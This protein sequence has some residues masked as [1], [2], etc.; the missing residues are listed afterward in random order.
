MNRY[1]L[2][3]C[4]LFVGLEVAL[5]IAPADALKL[6]PVRRAGRGLA[7]R[8]GSCQPIGNQPLLAV[9][10]L[11]KTDRGDILAVSTPQSAYP[12]L[13]FYVPY[14]ITPQRPAE[15][16]LESPDPADPAYRQQRTVVRLTQASAGVVGIPFPKTEQA[17]RPNQEYDFQL[18]VR[19]DERDASINQFVNFA[20]M[21][22]VLQPGTQKQLVSST[23]SDRLRLYPTLG[24][25]DEALSTL[26]SLR[27]QNPSD[28]QLKSEWQKLLETLDL[29]KIANQPLGDC[30]KLERPPSRELP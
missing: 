9:M 10:P 7:I 25:W 29:G 8:S 3:L 4:A 24:L 2:Y 26:V 6:K 18:V 1:C 30:C 15:L 16:R 22:Q 5:A 12:T 21:R 11:Y 28:R 19:C 27:R 23:T 13:W 20:V 17:L 14:A